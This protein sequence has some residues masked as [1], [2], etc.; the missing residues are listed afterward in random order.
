MRGRMSKNLLCGSH[1]L[2]HFTERRCY[3]PTKC[4]PACFLKPTQRQCRMKEPPQKVGCL[5]RLAIGIWEYQ[6][7][8]TLSAIALVLLEAKA[9]VFVQDLLGQTKFNPHVSGKIDGL[10]IA[11]RRPEAYLFGRLDC[12]FI[13]TVAHAANHARHLHLA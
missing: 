10:A 8:G 13:Q 12:C 3:R 1:W 5:V 6:R 7:Q 11:F 9:P 2:P 4:P